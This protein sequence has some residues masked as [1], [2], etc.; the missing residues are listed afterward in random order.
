MT[1]G[2][3]TTERLRVAFLQSHLRALY[4]HGQQTEASIALK[5]LN[6]MLGTGRPKS[7]RRH[8]HVRANFCSERL[9]V[10]AFHANSFKHTAIQLLAAVIGAAVIAFCILLTYR[11]AHRVS[12]KI[13]HTGMLGMVRLSAFIMLCI[14]VFH[15]LPCPTAGFPNP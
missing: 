6:R 1:T 12:G 3:K 11:Y 9:A 5:V 15:L 14:G 8:L 2:S 7:V 4:W 10:G 13:G